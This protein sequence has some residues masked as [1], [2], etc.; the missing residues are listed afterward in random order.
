MVW[1]IGNVLF[2]LEEVVITTIYFSE[3][4]ALC[5]PTKKRKQKTLKTQGWE[6]ARFALGFY[7]FKSCGVFFQF[8]SFVL[9]VYRK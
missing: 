2:A 1:F 4:K 6:N 3:G 7:A 8:V 5:F 9:A